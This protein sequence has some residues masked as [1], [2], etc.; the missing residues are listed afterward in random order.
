M[1]KQ[2]IAVLMITFSL[3]AMAQNNDEPE[4][5]GTKQ[6]KF[7]H[8]KASEGS[9]YGTWKAANHSR[10]FSTL[11]GERAKEVA[12]EV[13]LE[14]PPHESADCLRCHVTAYDAKTHQFPKAI[15]KEEGVQCESCHGPAS[16][17]LAAGQVLR[18]NK[19]N[20]AHRFK[21]VL[22]PDEKT[23]VQCHNTESPTWKPE[24]YTTSNGEKVGFDFSQA[25]KRVLHD[26]PNTVD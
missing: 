15:T 4:Y 14:T 22:K 8:N 16:H 21:T 2:S 20:P 9:P 18:A 24:K 12:K 1:L 25:L 26:N 17:H 11:L 7:C 13:G 3:T 19:G 23:C 6:C 5:V 10:A